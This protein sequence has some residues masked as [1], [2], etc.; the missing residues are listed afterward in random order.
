V[1]NLTRMQLIRTIA[2]W[3]PDASDYRDPTTATR[4]ALRSLGRRYL[5]LSDEIADLDVPIRALVE[6]LNP[7]LL[8]RTGVGVESA[9]QLL[10]TAGDNPERLRSEASFAA[11][12]GVSPIPASSGMSVRHRHNR[13]GNRAANSALHMIVISRLRIDD[14]TKAYVQRR[15]AEGRSKLE[16][17]RCLKRYVA[18]E[19]YH[20]IKQRNT[21]INQL[22]RAA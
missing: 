10:V 16:I 8:E 22:P 3:R 15:T 6:H 19:I 20:L 7:A 18:R 21:E 17:M 12:C 9:A 1:R 14:A 2:T 11:L 4:M 13:G 5:E